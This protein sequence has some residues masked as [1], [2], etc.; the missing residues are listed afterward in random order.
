MRRENNNGT[1][2][3]KNPAFSRKNGR[4]SAKNT[5]KRWLSVT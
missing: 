5:S 1:G 3:W 4:F 2:V